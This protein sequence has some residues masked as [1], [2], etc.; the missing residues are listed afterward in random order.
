LHIY[1]LKRNYSEKKSSIYTETYLF[2]T[3]IFGTDYTILW[4]VNPLSFLFIM[5]TVEDLVCFFNQDDDEV[6]ESLLGSMNHA[7]QQIMLKLYHI[8]NYEFH[9]HLC[10]LNYKMIKIF[11]TP[12][13]APNIAKCNPNNLRNQGMLLQG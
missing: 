1:K 2:D 3:Y 5:L 12:H 4:S 11:Q 9:S 10:G 7:I 13:Y 8:Y 6:V